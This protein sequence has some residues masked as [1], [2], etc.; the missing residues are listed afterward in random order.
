MDLKC[1]IKLLL[2]KEIIKETDYCTDIND[3]V[4]VKEYAY[5]YKEVLI[6]LQDSVYDKDNII[7]DT[8][9]HGHKLYVANKRHLK[10]YLL[11]KID[12]NCLNT[13]VNGS[14]ICHHI[15]MHS[16]LIN[17]FKDDIDIKLERICGGIKIYN[18]RKERQLEE[19]EKQKK[20]EV[21]DFLNQLP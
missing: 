12:E 3:N 1:L 16:Q 8:G 14:E 17:I 9:N 10:E 20:K 6:K 2:E 11:R 19:I 4:I 21:I 18:L 5:E 15:I 13:V 7:V